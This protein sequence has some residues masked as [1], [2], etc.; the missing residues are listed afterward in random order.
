MVLTAT[1]ATAGEG[2]FVRDRGLSPE[3]IGHSTPSDKPLVLITVLPHSAAKQ[4]R[5]VPGEHHEIFDHRRRACGAVAD[6]L[7]QPQS[8]YRPD[9]DQQRR[10]WRGDRR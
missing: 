5:T 8:L 9:A 7:H 4:G 2:Y 6:R 10:R 3:R 1:G